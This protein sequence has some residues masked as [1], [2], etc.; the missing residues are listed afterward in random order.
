MV[1]QRS[2]NW[3]GQESV[4]WEKQVAKA[5]ST[6]K[7][8]RRAKLDDFQDAEIKDG[9]YYARLTKAGCSVTKK[10][11]IPYVS[12][13]FIILEG[14]YEG[15]A[16]RRMDYLIDEDE[17]RQA[18]KQ[19]SFAKAMDG[20]EY[21][22]SSLDLKELPALVSALNKDR[23]IVEV[24]IS[25]WQGERSHGYNLYINKVL[26]EQ[27]ITE[28][29]L[30]DGDEDD[31]EE[32]EDDSEDAQDNDQDAEVDDLEAKASKSTRTKTPTRTRTL[33][34]SAK[35]SVKTTLKKRTPSRR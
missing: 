19:K 23:P 21:D 30:S 3:N 13:K 2:S 24:N 14:V 6:W 20:M 15:T 31:S 16:V 32:D 35:K 18:A 5:K 4:D 29:G 9:R 28:L 11:K 27:E 10:S 12:L 17:E 22:V 33:T 8:S 25:N 34:H 1:R 7:T 26:T